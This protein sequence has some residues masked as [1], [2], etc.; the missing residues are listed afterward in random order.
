MNHGR[1]LRPFALATALA[2]LA[3]CETPD[4]L[5]EPP[6]DDPLDGYAG[7]LAEAGV[8]TE[9][10]W[11]PQQEYLLSGYKAL[12]EEHRALQAR[13]AALQA[14]NQNLQVRLASEGDALADERRLRAQVEAELQALRDTRRG[15]EARVLALGIE[16][17]KLEQDALLA[18]IAGLQ[19]SLEQAAPGSAEAAAPT[20]GGR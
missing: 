4:L 6:P 7:S 15:L 2:L 11:G 19:R 12:H 5:Y 13:L 20:G 8:T 9:V 3:A 14:E 18:R 16:K 10:D 17:A 1:P